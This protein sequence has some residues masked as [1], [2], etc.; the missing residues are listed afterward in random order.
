DG[1][2]KARVDLNYSGIDF[3]HGPDTTPASSKAAFLNVTVHPTDALSLTGGIRYSRDKKTYTYYRSNPDGTLPPPCNFAAPGGPT[4]NNNP[5]NCL[6]NGIYGIS[7]S[8]RGSR[9]D[10]RA[11]ADYR[12]SDELLVYGSV[13]T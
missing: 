6:L 11:V 8:F 9:W 2:L 4:G 12:F 7:D 5:P 13:A 10:W 1:S 3:I